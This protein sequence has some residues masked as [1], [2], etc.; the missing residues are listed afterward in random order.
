MTNDMI[1]HVKALKEVDENCPVPALWA[2]AIADACGNP[3]RAK[4]R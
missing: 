1:F 4:A 2:M 3:D